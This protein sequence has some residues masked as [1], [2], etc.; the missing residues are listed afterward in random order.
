MPINYND[1][2]H[3]ISHNQARARTTIL[4]FTPSRIDAG[5]GRADTQFSKM[6]RISGVLDSKVPTKKRS[7]IKIF[8]VPFSG[9]EAETID[10]IHSQN[11][12]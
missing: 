10:D 12:S 2:C 7:K 11:F 5:S 4:G 3:R 8:D 9:E 1:L 6:Y